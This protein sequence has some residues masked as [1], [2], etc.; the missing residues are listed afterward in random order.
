MTTVCN[1]RRV[2]AMPDHETFSIAP[3]G[4]LVKRYL[5]QSAVSIDPF[6]RNKQW[7]TYTNDLNPETSAQYHLE[8]LDFLRLMK[9]QGVHPDLVIFD[10]PYS[11]EQC[12]RAYQSVGKH[13]SQRDTQIFRRW[14]EYK[15][16]IAQMIQPD[17]ISIYCGWDSAGMGEKNGFEMVEILL[18][19]HGAGHNDTIVTV[20]KKVKQPES[21]SL[22]DE[23]DF[24]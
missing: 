22:F 21:M 17:G 7:A 19:C 9:K 1:L 11:L 8:A 24:A 3:I 18:V 14:S 12:S 13:V 5:R 10:P 16:L 2:W 6:A 15:M 20:E 4:D 23:E